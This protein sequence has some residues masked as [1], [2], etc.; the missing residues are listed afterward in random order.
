MADHFN[1]V[2][3]YTFGEVFNYSDTLSEN[4]NMFHYP[5]AWSIPQTDNDPADPTVNVDPDLI[6]QLAEDEHKNAEE[7]IRNEMGVHLIN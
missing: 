1:K 7:I 2:N 3:A 6:N 4:M 5:Y